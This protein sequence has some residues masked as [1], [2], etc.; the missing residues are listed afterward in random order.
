[1]ITLTPHQLSALTCKNNNVLV[2]V[3]K[4]ND[5]ITLADGKTQISID[6]SF[7]KVKHSV[8]RGIVV[9][10]P[11]QLIFDMS[12]PPRSLMEWHTEM[13]VMPGDEVIFN[14]L[15]TRECLDD[16]SEPIVMCEGEAYFPVPYGCLYVAK[17][18]YYE[19]HTLPWY[20]M[21]I[22]LNGY[23]IMEPIQVDR[24]EIYADDIRL[25]TLDNAARV[26]YAAKPNTFYPY[27]DP[28]IVV[29]PGEVYMMQRNCDIP[30]EYEL[31]ASLQGSQQFYICQSRHFTA[32]VPE[33]IILTEKGVI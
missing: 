21:T 24:G 26:K 11:D 15:V 23:N 32:R 25:K 6:T 30:L 22:P 17:R 7:E 27:G 31:H 4:G 12:V 20:V 9:A 10:V 16:P 18:K 5:T 28:D 13:Q 33:E 19:G 2:K 29:K 1:M 14:Y 3:A 8:T